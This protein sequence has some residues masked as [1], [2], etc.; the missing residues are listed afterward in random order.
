LIKETPNTSYEKLASIINTLDDSNT[1]RLFDQAV[2]GF[3]SG[4][5]TIEMLKMTPRKY[6]RSLKK[7]NNS[8]LILFFENKYKLSELGEFMHQIL[9]NEIATY[10]FGD[11]TLLEPLKK[12]GTKTEIRI[13]NNYCD[14]TSLIATSIE[15]SKSEILLATRYLDMVVVQS[16]VFALQRNVKIKTI[17]NEKIDFSAFIKLI[18][19]FLKNIRPN[20]LKFVAGRD[21]YRVGSIPFSFIIVDDEVTIFEIP[22]K[23]FQLAFVSSDKEVAKGLTNLFWETWKESKTLRIP[24]L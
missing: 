5:E 12:M 17:T 19:F 9:F 15:K 8:G 21:N 10:L 7:L 13:I 16:I 14:L 20:P 3:E 18:G 6:Y 1:L 23:E 24:N 2:V 11:Q 4:K 22:D